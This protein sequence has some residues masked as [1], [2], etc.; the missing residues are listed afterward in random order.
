M[1]NW[2]TIG[3]LSLGAILGLYLASHAADPS[4]YYYGLLLSICSVLAAF[5]VV[6][7]ITAPAK[8][9]P[10]SGDEIV[11]NDDVVRAGVIAT[12]FWGVVGFLAGLVIALQLAFPVLNFDLP[13]L[14]F[15]RLRPVHTS[16]VIFAFGG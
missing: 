1:S 11:Y 9:A 5:F 15:G 6:K 3:L 2:L 10:V 13:W 16:A 12:T 4:F 8:P 14:N 7:S